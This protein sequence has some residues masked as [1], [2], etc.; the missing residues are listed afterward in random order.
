MQSR[1]ALLSDDMDGEVRVDPVTRQL[2]ST[3]ASVYQELPIAVAIPT[4]SADVQKLIHFANEYDLG[5][6]PRTAGTSLAG[7]VVGSGLVVD[8]GQSLNRILEVNV[9]EQWV[10]VEP[11]VV[12]DEL[13]IELAKHNL[14]FG[15]ETSSSNR[16]M[17]GGMVGNNSCG[18]NSIA[19]GTTR[20]N[21]IELKGFLSDGSEAV[22][23]ELSDDEFNE[24]CQLDS[25][26][27]EIYRG[28]LEQFE[29]QE[30]QQ[31]ITNSFPK[32]E[33][34]R[35]NTGYAIDR[36]IDSSVFGR[37]R[38]KFNFCQLLVGSEG[39]LFFATEIKL[40]LIPLPP[41]ERGLLCAH[42]DNVADALKANVIATRYKLYSS[43]LIDRKVL[44]GAARNSLQREN[45]SVLEG[46]PDAI[47][48]MELRGDSSQSVDLQVQQIQEEL[49]TNDLGYALPLL[50]GSDIDKIW[51]LRRAGLG[52]AASVVGDTKPVALI[53]D[54]AVTID[55]LPDYIAD[56]DRL[57]REKYQC[58]CVFYG[59]AGSGELHL[60]PV[61]NLKSSKGRK[62]FRQIAID[63]ANCVK[64]YRG[65]LS[66]EHGDGRLR[67]EFLEWMV[68]ERC[69]Q[70]LRS[71]K[72]LF[73][74]RNIFNPGKIVDA[75][76]MDESLRFTDASQSEDESKT[77]FDFQETQGLRRA[78]EMC[79]GS[80]DCRK[81]VKSGGTMCPSY[82]A[83]RN[84][85][86][87]TRARANMLRHVLSK[88]NA[89]LADEQLKDVMDLCL[90]CKGCKAECP[91]NVDVAKMKGE[92]LQA[93]H[94]ANG[95]PKRARLLADIHRM[96][97]W[98]AR[99]PRLANATLDGAV[100]SRLFKRMYGFT[101]K[102]NLPRFARVNLIKWF[103]GHKVHENAGQNGT[104][105]FFGDEF[106]SYSEP[107][108]GVAAIELLERLGWRVELVSELESG[109]ASVSQGQLRK[110][111]E[112][113]SHNVEHLHRIVS[114]QTPLISVEPSAILTF[115]DEY[116]DLLRGS[117]KEKA[118]RLAASCLTLEEFLDQGVQNGLV[119]REK[120][121]ERTQVIRLHGHC[122][123]KSLVGMVP[124]IRCLQIPKGYRVRLIPSGCCGMAGSFGYEEE[125]YQL[126]MQIG[127]L[128]LFPTVRNEPADHLICATGASCRQQILDGTERASLHPAQILRQALIEE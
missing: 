74:P 56:V 79:S 108:V 48:I 52:V 11:G 16:A 69:Y 72:T 57:L 128:V 102:R 13:N 86:D 46:D 7:Q 2:Y 64:R 106:T 5:L 88:E 99:F 63:V 26:E 34:T 55:D 20:E 116:P 21:T 73:D 53:E 98:G 109:R 25:L 10:R 93:Y 23:T 62:K 51:S 115:R 85:A 9:D 76:P 119:A 81:T 111:R 31:E 70:L 105:H 35:R 124:T 45:L 33:I 77:L 28:V 78:A 113:A 24:K 22:F 89:S 126:S 39:T 87:T 1:L 61:L 67:G 91:S 44:E 90:A 6:I 71:T 37:S 103:K 14:M 17:I 125:H 43:E 50:T 38:S 84:E 82:M 120:F 47:L 114:Q 96:N 59:H 36:L 101:Q 12:R 19:F 68:G 104:V 58:E 65:S 49:R 97:R 30:V 80:G 66:G 112:T 117:E 95:I 60:R 42:F 100:V 15:P 54:A 41:P 32:A 122:H 18:S 94:D 121:H 3:D 92:F 75:P 83:T 127:E 118:K 8:V 123:Q 4:S 27:G 107:D 29:S 40:R 110:A